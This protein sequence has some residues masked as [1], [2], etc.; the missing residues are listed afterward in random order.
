MTYKTVFE[1]HNPDTPRYPSNK[2]TAH[3][4]NIIFNAQNDEE[5]VLSSLRFFNL[6]QKNVPEYFGELL[7]I[8]VY[9]YKICPIS[10]KGDLDTHISQLAF[11]W[12]VGHF[13][14]EITLEEAI[15]DKFKK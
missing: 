14:H 2:A 11:N 6:R 1:F 12:K 4:S 8:Q 13:S 5:A 9:Q 3:D 15:K 7:S 10:N